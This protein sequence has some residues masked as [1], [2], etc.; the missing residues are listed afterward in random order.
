MTPRIKAIRNLLGIGLPSKNRT[1]SDGGNSK[2]G[3]ILEIDAIAPKTHQITNPTFLS[4]SGYQKV[5]IIGVK[6]RIPVS[7]LANFTRP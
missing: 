2:S 4:N 6:A 1:V 5:T 7:P 3:S